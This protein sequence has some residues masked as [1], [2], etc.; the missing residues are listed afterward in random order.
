MLVYCCNLLDGIALID[1]TGYY[2]FLH[3]YRYK[4]VNGFSGFNATILSL[5]DFEIFIKFSIPF[6]NA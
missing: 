3:N 2:F 1:A 6:N 5:L 4:I